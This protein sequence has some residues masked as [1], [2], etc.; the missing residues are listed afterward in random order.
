MRCFQ[1]L[2]PAVPKKNRSAAPSL[3]RVPQKSVVFKRL[4]SAIIAAA[5]V[6]PTFA[7][8]N[9][10][11]EQIEAFEDPK[12]PTPTEYAPINFNGV[13]PV[14]E[15]SGTYAG[16]T[17]H[18]VDTTTNTYSAHADV[19]ANR[20]YGVG[21]VGNPFVTNV[22]SA[23]ADL[24]IPNVVNPQPT[25]SN[26]GPAPGTFDGGAKI[27]NNSYVDNEANDAP[28]AKSNLDAL[29]RL[30]FMIQQADVTFVAAAA[31]DS[32]MDDLN[33][34]YLDW[35]AYNSL[36]VAGDGTNFLPGTNLPGKPH[37]DV[38]LPGQA[39]FTTA[40]VSGYVAGLYGTAQAAGQTSALHDVVMRSLIMAGADKNGYVR[41]T[42]NN[43][44][45]TIGAGFADYSRSLSILNSGQQPILP[46]NSNTITGT[47]TTNPNG[48]AYST[49]SGGSQDALLF[50]TN[51]S[52]AG[53]TASLNWDVTQNQPAPG[54]ID[55]TDGG[56]IFPTLGL[57]VRPVTF[58]GSNYTLGPSLGDLTLQ[59][60]LPANTDNVEYIYSTSTL[61]AGNYAFMITGDPTL[62]T[63]VGFSYILAV[64]SQ[65]NVNA[66]GNW[67]LASNWDDNTI[68]N[69][70]DRLATLGS[71]TTAPHTVFTDIP[72][73]LG[74]LH[75][76]NAN[77]YVLAG[78]GSLTMQASAT[79]ATINVD[80]GIQEINVPLTL[81]SNTTATIQPGA[82][83]VIGD[84]L[85]LNSSVFFSVTGGGTMTIESI[86]TLGNQ[87]MIS[88]AGGT[89]LQ[90]DSSITA[91]AASLPI[92]VAG[93]LDL[94]QMSLDLDLQSAP[95]GQY[96][97]VDYS[98]GGTILGQ[99]AS[100]EGLPPGAVID[101][102]GT[103]TNPESIVA[104]VPE[105]TALTLLT[106]IS[107]LS[108]NRRR[109]RL[110][111]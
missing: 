74:S 32:G 16:I 4:F 61:P 64:P 7:H 66:S 26:N 72:I 1:A 84:P 77:R 95:D 67:N 62:T 83:L 45:V 47:P 17:F 85:T 5:A 44:S 42:A 87:A 11:V 88:V 19:V 65:W 18:A 38:I 57:E 30:D 69:G 68:P 13:T 56:T 27:I 22:Y 104:V 106:A 21:M 108:L 43:L 60:Y 97:I 48:W 28:V 82:T 40:S 12:D 81:A 70:I 102:D 105:P 78:A 76:N 9:V 34:A 58:N 103:A 100:I 35:S 53:I 36:A 15:T 111:V 86:V 93:T 54:E 79:N 55:T 89:T 59:S 110:P 31:V 98:N 41:Q 39:S 10:V 8:A 99:F 24:F 73:T 25:L 51:A 49:I 107:I 90:G 92:E 52:M 6:C 14:T 23:A 109:P 37:A 91:S 71:I 3:G 75:F 46:I 33:G 63:T 94:S 29:R 50:H 101:Y 96:V 80:Q 2:R 20:I